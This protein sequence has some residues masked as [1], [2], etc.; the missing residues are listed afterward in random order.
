MAKKHSKAT[1]ASIQI[2]V[3]EFV[4]EVIAAR[5]GESISIGA[6]PEVDHRNDKAVEELW[7]ALSRGYAVEHTRVESFEGQLANSARIERLLTPVK[8]RWPSVCLACC[9]R[10]TRARRWRFPWCARWPAN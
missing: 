2:E 7:D 3:C 9:R 5:T 6:R 8:R 1:K 10:S 4:R